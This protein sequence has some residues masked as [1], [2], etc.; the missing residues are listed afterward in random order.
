MTKRVTL[1]AS[2]AG[3]SA[4]TG[5]ALAGSAAANSSPLFNW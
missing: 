1:K 5:L 4:I 2:V 3:G